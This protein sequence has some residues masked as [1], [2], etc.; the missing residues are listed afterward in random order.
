MGTND[1]LQAQWEAEFEALC[2]AAPDRRLGPTPPPFPVSVFPGWIAAFVDHLT[3]AL[4]VP[5]DMPGVMVLGSLSAAAGR[6]QVQALPGWTQ[7][8]CLWVAGVADPGA[9]KS[10]VT[11]QVNAALLQF[12]QELQDAAVGNIATHKIEL[13]QAQQRV[14]ST[15][16]ALNSAIAELETA[17]A[18]LEALTSPSAPTKATDAKATA[19]KPS[20]KERKAAEDGVTKAQAA[21]H[22]A[23][24]DASDAETALARCTAARPAMPRLVIA[25][26][27]SE[28]VAVTLSEQGS[29][30]LVSDEPIIWSNAAGRYG[31]GSG[32]PP[33]EVFLQAY[34]GSTITVDR[35]SLETPQRAVDPSLTMQVMAQPAALKQLMDNRA[36]SGRGFLDRWIFAMPTSVLGVRD[37][38]AGVAGMR[39]TSKTRTV[40]ND[41]YRAMISALREHGSQVISFNQAAEDV[42]VDW[43]EAIE[44]ELGPGGSL[45]AISGVVSKRQGDLARLAALL[46]IAHSTDAGLLSRDWLKPIGPQRVKDAIEI[47][48]WSL[49][50]TMHLVDELELDIQ[51]V[52]MRAVL[53]WLRRHVNPIDPCVQRRALFAGLRSPTRGIN[54]VTDLEPALAALVEDGWLAPKTEVKSSAGGRPSPQFWVHPDVWS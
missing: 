24:Q 54:K 51:V 46:H 36:L 20:A 45:S 43:M 32:P 37:V 8:V 23:E 9:R 28:A 11:K 38:R 48:T 15:I 7:P 4:Q 34:S 47:V 42:Y 40:Y 26:T 27:T 31:S 44:P 19:A 18:A 14:D 17:R 13:H 25:D 53:A 52:Q 49:A 22:A 10:E 12:E 29:I 33:V 21:L 3:E 35:R 39:A 1:P 2:R 16:K 30:A 6:V 50:H 5:V 41:T